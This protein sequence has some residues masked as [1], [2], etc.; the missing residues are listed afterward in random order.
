MRAV[1]GFVVL[2]ASLASQSVLADPIEPATYP[3]LPH[4]TVNNEPEVCGS[5][6]SVVIEAFKGPQFQLSLADSA[7]PEAEVQPVSFA[8]ANSLPSAESRSL[9]LTG[10]EVLADRGT[11]I[12]AHV[13]QKSPMYEDHTFWLFKDSA[14]YR[15]TAKAI[16]ARQDEYLDPAD[17]LI[18]AHN[19]MPPE[20]PYD[21]EWIG[22]PSWGERAFFIVNGSLHVL[23]RNDRVDPTVLELWRVGLTSTQLACRASLSGSNPLKAGPVGALHDLLKTISGQEGPASGTMHTLSFVQ[24][25]GQPVIERMALRPWSVPSFEPYNS[26]ADIDAW[27][28]YWGQASLWNHRM[29][30]QMKLLRPK[31]LERLTRY[32]RETFW[33]D[34]LAAANWAEVSVER[35][36]GCYF[37]FPASLHDL[38]L[39]NPRWRL[40]HALLAGKPWADIAPLLPLD[41]PTG[42]QDWGWFPMEP[43]LDYALEQPALLSQLLDQKLD[44]DASNGFGK[45]PLMYAAHF[46]LPQAARL[47][48]QHGAKVNAQTGVNQTEIM[49]GGG[50]RIDIWSRTVLMYAL[51]NAGEEMIKLLLEAGADA[52]AKDSAGRGALDYLRMNTRLTAASQQAIARDLMLAGYQEHP[53]P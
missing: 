4:L 25:R 45:T 27:L 40:R 6:E 5:F 18:D 14:S 50:Y 20:A 19:V 3:F 30:R 46:N 1:F 38:D 29:L 31:A 28:E 7:W 21:T 11:R 23:V 42:S 26:N 15:A 35:L 47:L 12:L 9:L 13:V 51:E 53:V 34:D 16:E 48:L 41:R 22:V 2:A 17:V 33:V 39:D 49:I 36:M 32:Y 10:V 44:P 8:S 52:T 43:A 37:M 24:Q